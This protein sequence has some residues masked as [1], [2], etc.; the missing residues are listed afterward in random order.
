MSDAVN[1]PTQQDLAAFR[2]GVLPDRI[3]CLAWDAC[4]SVRISSRVR[5]QETSE[6]NNYSLAMKER[7]RSNLLLLS[8][9]L[10][11]A[12]QSLKRKGASG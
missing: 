4:L 12:L 5:F 10:E 6:K 1:H 2:L 7:R 3:A 11:Q 9:S 8:R